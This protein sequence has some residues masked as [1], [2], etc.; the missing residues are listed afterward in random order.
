MVNGKEYVGQAKNIYKRNSGELSSL[1]NNSFHNIHMQRSWNKHGPDNFSLSI[2]FDNLSVSQL[3]DYEQMAIL[4]RDMPDPSKGYNISVGGANNV[5][6]KEVRE[7]ISKTQLNKT[8]GIKPSFD[9][10]EDLYVNQGLTLG[11]IGD[12]FNVD[13][14]S[15][16]N[17]LIEYDI[18]VRSLSDAMLNKSGGTKPSK[19]ELI[20]LYVN[21][22]LT[23]EVIGNMFNVS[24]NSIS[25]WL[26]EYDI[27]ARSLS[28]AQLLMNGGTKPS[29]DVLEDLYV[30]KG[31][32]T[33]AIGVMFNV[34]KGTI[35]RWLDESGIEIRTT[36]E[37]LLIRH[38]STKPSKDELIDLY[39][40]QCLSTS[41]IADMFNTG[42]NSISR[43]LNEYDIPA[44]S[45]SDAHLIRRGGVKPSKDVLEDLYI[46]QSL[47]PDVIGDMFNVT[48]VTIRNWLRK[49]D[50]PLRSKSESTTLYYKKERSGDSH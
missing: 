2:L 12:M 16:K 19:D 44:R 23:L 37:S 9:V 43:W 36:A 25:R 32:S 27:P 17:W 45:L 31:L 6:T 33:E 3:N 15:I 38:G 18:P 21:Q 13:L 8:G 42:S 29:Y 28:D 40:N 34:S 22:C 49:Q 46:N 26:V 11:V 39:V 47:T 7:K 4:L 10:L 24:N 14:S 35:S 30:N 50:I 20:E 1:R 48:G 5:I 41:V